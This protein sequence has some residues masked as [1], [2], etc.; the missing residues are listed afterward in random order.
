VEF[1]GGSPASGVCLMWKRQNNV[2]SVFR[3]W[4]MLMYLNGVSVRKE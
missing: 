3:K 1:F 2:W 4:E